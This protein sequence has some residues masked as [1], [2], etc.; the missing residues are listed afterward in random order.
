MTKRTCTAEGCGRPYYARG[1]CTMHWSRAR[2][3]GESLPPPIVPIVQPCKIDGCEQLHQA[4]GYCKKHYTR[5]LRHGDPLANFTIG[6]AHPQWA[7][8]AATY[9]A[10]HKRLDRLRGLASGY[11]CVDC[12]QPAH[13]WSYD[14]TSD[15][16]RISTEGHPYSPDLAAYSPRCQPCHVRF[17]R[18]RK[19]LC[20]QGHP[21]SGAN[22]IT[23]KNGSRACRACKKVSDHKNY[24]KVGT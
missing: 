11:A 20:P 15:Q 21:F 7:G 14:N 22:L 6:E 16:E 23:R 24:M 3:R 1:Y 18:P 13:H 2:Y 4:R 8:T 19:S 17:D 9:R 12:G 10:V 5:W